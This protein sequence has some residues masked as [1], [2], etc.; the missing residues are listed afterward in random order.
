MAHELAAPLQQTGRIRQRCA[1]KE[2]YVYVRSEYIHVT[3][4]RIA[5]TCD[6]T[7]IMQKLP[8]FIAAFAHHLKPLKRD[9][10]QFTSMCFHPHIDGGIPLDSA[11]ESQ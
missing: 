7:A 8:D 11:I 1:A 3:E 4:G 2:A 5:Q 6:W 9:G 10:S